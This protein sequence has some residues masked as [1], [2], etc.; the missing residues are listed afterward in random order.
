MIHGMGNP[1]QEAVDYVTQLSNYDDKCL[2][3]CR[4][5]PTWSH[6]FFK[7]DFM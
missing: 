5:W 7:R 2:K 6:I 1:N 4:L 3:Q